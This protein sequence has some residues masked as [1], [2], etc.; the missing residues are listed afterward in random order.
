[1][2]IDT[3]KYPQE[4]CVEFAVKGSTQVRMLQ[5][6]AENEEQALKAIRKDYKVNFIKAV[7]PAEKSS[8]EE[9]E[10]LFGDLLDAN[11]GVSPYLKELIWR[12]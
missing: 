8:I 12:S 11:L 1:M 9:L 6:P 10:E 3:N 5:V 2:A 4:F 7:Y